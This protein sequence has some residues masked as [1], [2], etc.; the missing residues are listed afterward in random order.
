MGWAVFNPNDRNE[1]II[2]TE[3]GIWSSDNINAGSVEWSVNSGTIPNVPFT[4]L[5]LDP[6]EQ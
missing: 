6:T 1:V 2:G 3:V 4:Q 5:A